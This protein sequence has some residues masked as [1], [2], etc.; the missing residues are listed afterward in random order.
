[1]PP[2]AAPLP[3]LPQTECE[4]RAEASEFRGASKWLTEAATARAVPGE[5]IERLDVCLNEAL[6]N[7]ISYGG[8]TALAAPIQIALTVGSDEQTHHATV[9]VS[10]AGAEFDPATTA[11]RPRPATLSTATPGGHGLRILRSFADTLTHRYTDGRNH[12]SFGVR[13]RP[14]AGAD[15]GQSRA[16]FQRG[17][18]RR[19]RT[20]A[21]THDRRRGPRRTLGSTWIPLFQDVDEPTVMQELRECEVL[22]VPA[23]APLLKRNA[24]NQN[25]FILLSGTLAAHLSDDLSLE[26]AIVVPSGAC[27]GEL[28]VIDG[29][30]VSALVLAHTEVRVLV[31]P[32]DLFWY[33]LMVLPGVARNLMLSLT[34]RMRR[35]N[36]ITLKA[37][38]EQLELQH[39][40]K[41][42]DFA[43]QLQISMLPLQRPMF[44]DRPD[45]EICGYMEAASTVGGDLF[46]AFF[47]DDDHLFFCIGDVS[48]H[49]VGAALFMARAVGLL[50]NLAMNTLLPDEVLTALNQRLCIGND[51]NLFVTLAC[52]FLNLKTG[53]LCYSNG[54]HCALVR[55]GVNAASE[56]VRPKGAL[57][58]AIDGARFTAVETT[59][60]IGETLFCYTDGVS[61]AQ[62]IGEEEFSVTRCMTLLAEQFAQPI[63]QQLAALRVA[64]ATFS[65]TRTLADDCTMLAMRRTGKL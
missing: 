6:A 13:W 30:P 9:T 5:L 49:G 50:R 12:L 34:E 7:V 38:R 10:D 32:R 11:A 16:L 52:G 39:L 62:N 56:L 53:R 55:V 20:V 60:D 61:E 19:S 4:I 64:V 17:P 29:K 33:R 18:D 28:S 2:S 36:E 51:T 46:D 54:G 26:N 31:L 42:L 47:V 43:R 27:I 35:T 41:E 3:I 23:G 15:F 45:L 1:L 14:S 22:Q 40:R 63:E 37:Q 48:G 65:G 59:L 21:V 58:G 8:D 25:V 24:M 57:V 44:S